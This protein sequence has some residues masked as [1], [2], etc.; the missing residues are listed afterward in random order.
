MT[1]P[2]RPL[3]TALWKARSRAAPLPPTYTT[4]KG[5]TPQRYNRLEINRRKPLN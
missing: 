3:A 1:T 5:T 2:S 4:P